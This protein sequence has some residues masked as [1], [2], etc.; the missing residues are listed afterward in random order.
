MSS[1]HA[2]LLFRALLLPW[3]GCKWLERHPVAAGDKFQVLLPP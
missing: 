2:A 3:R 1:I